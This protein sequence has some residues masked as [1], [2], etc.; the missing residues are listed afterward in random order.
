MF[1][2]N[3]DVEKSS[4]GLNHFWVCLIFINN[5]KDPFRVLLTPNSPACDAVFDFNIIPQNINFFRKQKIERLL[6]VCR[7]V[8]LNLFQNKSFK[9]FKTERTEFWNKS[10]K[11]NQ[12]KM[13]QSS[14]ATKQLF[15][16]WMEYLSLSSIKKRNFS[17]R[18][19]IESKKVFHWKKCKWFTSNA[20][21]I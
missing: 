20:E 10:L 4:L 8:V 21:T 13:I 17:L 11:W 6:S 7:L 19:K 3:V 16:Y 14:L 5:S 9:N 1:V 2:F 12:Q 18:Q 15:W